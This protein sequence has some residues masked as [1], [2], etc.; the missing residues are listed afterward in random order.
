MWKEEIPEDLWNSHWQTDKNQV[1]GAIKHLLPVILF[2]P[3]PF[4]YWRGSFRSLIPTL[5][6]TPIS[7]KLRLT[8]LS[9]LTSCRDQRPQFENE[10]LMPEC[11]WIN[12]QMTKTDNEKCDD[13]PPPVNKVP[14]CWDFFLDLYIYLCIYVY[15]MASWSLLAMACRPHYKSKD[16]IVNFNVK[17]LLLCLQTHT[18]LTSA[19]EWVKKKRLCMC[20]CVRMSTLIIQSFPSLSYCHFLRKDFRFLV[21]NLSCVCRVCVYLCSSFAR[22]QS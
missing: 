7:T 10:A 20:I 18:H 12:G 11:L 8:C 22:G 21:P 16:G 17:M 1:Y 13:N 9:T 14:R 15:I 5:T 4:S 6:S 3:S 2:T 19:H